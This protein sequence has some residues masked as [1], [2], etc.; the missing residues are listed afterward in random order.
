MRQKNLSAYTPPGVNYPPYI[1]INEVEGAVEIT[2]RSD[3]TPE[4][5]CGSQAMIRIEKRKFESLASE[6]LAQLA[7][8]SNYDKPQ[9]V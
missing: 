8:P 1:S 2:V 5:A 3:V 7:G 9:T 6:A 4:G